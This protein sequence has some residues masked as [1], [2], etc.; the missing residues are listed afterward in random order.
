MSASP[1]TRIVHGSRTVSELQTLYAARA[2]RLPTRA[3]LVGTLESQQ[4]SLSWRVLIQPSLGVLGVPEDFQPEIVARP[5]GVHQHAANGISG[6][7]D[8]GHRAARSM[9]IR[10]LTDVGKQRLHLVQ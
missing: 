3:T 5:M 6:A 9:F 4:A 2:D 7:G 1:S 10:K 8:N